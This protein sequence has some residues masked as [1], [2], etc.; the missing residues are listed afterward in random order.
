[1]NLLNYIKSFQ[2]G[3][4]KKPKNIS[5]EK[6]HEALML[7]NSAIKNGDKFPQLT[8]AQAILETGWFKSP[9]GKFN[10]FGQKATQNQKG[11][12]KST[13]EVFNGNTTRLPQKFRDYD[14]IDEAMSDRQRLWGNKYKDKTTIEEALYSIWQYDKNKK[15]G[16][17][18]ATDPNYDNKIKSILNSIGVSFESTSNNEVV[19][20]DNQNQVNE[21]L[22]TN[23]PNID[24]R[25]ISIEDIY[26]IYKDQPQKADEL[27]K[28]KEAYD[29]R[30]QKQEE[31]K[32]Q[33]EQDYNKQLLLEAQKEKETLMSLLVEPESK[34]EEY[35][36]NILQS[37][38][39]QTPAFQFQTDW[40]KPQIAQTGG[41]I[42][43][44]IDDIINPIGLD[45]KFN[46]EEILSPQ[47]VAF[48]MKNEGF[49][50]KPYL[51]SS[52]I[53]TIGYGTIKYPDGT[54][55]TMGDREISK[56][57]A[58]RF[59]NHD[60][61]VIWNEIK[62]SIKTPLTQN[63]KDSLISFAYNIGTNG[64]K[65]STLLK[66]LNKN[67][68]DPSIKNEFLRWNKVK[69]QVVNGLT[70]RRKR[71]ASLFFNGYQEG[72]VVSPLQQIKQKLL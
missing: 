3:G 44:K 54:P 5:D 68:N 62:D 1:M 24:I 66:K 20:I 6:W 26:E 63:Q 29:A 65:D 70:N 71:E 45:V 38:L 39:Q 58:L 25:T 51:D 9:S 60:L 8:L 64:F 50:T 11:S 56:E 16:K 59:K 42:K 67:P 40:F 27:A 17:G 43:P 13:T 4:L 12:Q 10:Y 23:I 34:N 2:E 61:G 35:N 30:L 18:Y 48:L 69:G 31:E 21:S 52:K 14:S 36:N 19:N 28:I 53:P 32:L 33:A 57:E 47:G 46:N 7:Y 22:Q 72:G 49:E 15:Q 55:V 37:S 41:Y